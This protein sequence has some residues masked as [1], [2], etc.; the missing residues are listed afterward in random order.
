MNLMPHVSPT[1]VVTGF[2]FT[3]LLASIVACAETPDTS[4][5]RDVE[6]RQT[7]QPLKACTSSRDVPGT[8]IEACLLAGGSEVRCSSGTSM[9][10]RACTAEEDC[11]TACFDR[12]EDV[13]EAPPKEDHVD[14]KDPPP[15]RLDPKR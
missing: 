9:C 8:F 12:V 4:E 15:D 5:R 10:C 1:R 7:Q 11:D 13:R 3:L 14:P 2:T 6:V